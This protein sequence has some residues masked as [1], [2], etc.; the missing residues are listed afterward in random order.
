M[1]TYKYQ[2]PYGTR[3]NKLGYAITT[4]G[5]NCWFNPDL[6]KWVD[7]TTFGGS[8]HYHC[9]TFK[10]FKRHLRKHPELNNQTVILVSKFIGYD[11]AAIWIK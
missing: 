1:W 3:C 9:K 6:N 2:Q 10:A 5:S 7:T 8:T 4:Y 11:I